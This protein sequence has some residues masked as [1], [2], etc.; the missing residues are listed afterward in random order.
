MNYLHLFLIVVIGFFPL[1]SVAGENDLVPVLSFADTSCGAWTRSQRDRSM[2]QIYLYWFR[3]FVSGYNYG[4]ETKQVP[5]NA[6]PDQDTL[7]LYVDKYC[8]E[9]P[10]RPFIG[11]AFQL[12]EELRVKK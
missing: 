5:L 10:L 2:R 8:R 12:V 9:Q 3:G 1:V 11:A 7:S 6:M 4:S